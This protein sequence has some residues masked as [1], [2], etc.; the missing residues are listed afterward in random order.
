MGVRGRWLGGE[1]E[2]R[3]RCDGCKGRRDEGGVVGVREGGMRGRCDGWEGE[4]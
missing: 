4:G 2:M 3:G 1:G